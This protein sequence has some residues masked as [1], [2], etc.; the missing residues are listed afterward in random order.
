M[1]GDIIWNTIIAINNLFILVH[2]K[3]IPERL[4]IYSCPE[5]FQC[6][7]VYLSLHYQPAQPLDIIEFSNLLKHKMNEIEKTDDM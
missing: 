3:D 1:D 4:V 6:I 7:A 2:I 5:L